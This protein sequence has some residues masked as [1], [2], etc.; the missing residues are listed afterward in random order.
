M[1]FQL[2]NC[3][4]AAQCKT[5]MKTGI[6]QCSGRS[7]L[8][9]QEEPVKPWWVNHFQSC[10]VTLCLT[11]VLFWPIGGDIA[12][13]FAALWETGFHHS[14]GGLSPEH[15]PELAYRVWEVAKRNEGW[16]ELRGKDFVCVC[17]SV[18]VTLPIHEPFSKNPCI[19]YWSLPCLTGGWAG[20]SEE[21]TGP[22]VRAPEMARNGRGY[23]HW[24]RDV[25]K[26]DA[27]QEH[28]E[29]EA[30]RDLSED[31]GRSRYAALAW[32]FNCM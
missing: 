28:E 10:A 8:Y 20:H 21:A 27:G 7:V 1:L 2:E 23:N 22:S 24:L 25:P 16:G 13:Y 15:C 3:S 29:Q 19:S 6:L 18:N 11:V 12:S 14:T 17:V 32:N 31:T 4:N 9:R 5:K 30:E 26:P